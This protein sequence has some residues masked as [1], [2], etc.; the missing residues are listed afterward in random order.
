MTSV[1]LIYP[2]FKPARDTSTFRFPPLGIAYVGAALRD[3]GYQV[4]LLDCTFLSRAE[5]LEKARA[6]HPEVVGVYAMITMREDALMFARK[7]RASARLLVAGGPFPSTDPAAFL[8]DFDAVVRGEGERTI[9][10]LLSAW[11]GGLPLD[12]VP[13]V[14][15]RRKPANAASTPLTSAEGP[16]SGPERTLEPDLD[17][18]PFPARDLLPNAEYIRHGKRKYGYSITSLMSSR[19]CPFDCEFCSNV[20]FGRSNRM[21]SPE[22]VVDEVEQALSLGYERIHFADDVFTLDRGRVEAIC[23]EIMRRGLRFG[24]ECLCRVD[25]IDYDLARLMKKAGCRRVFFGIESGSDGVLRMMNKKITTDRARRAVETARRARLRTGAFFILFYPGESDAT[26]EETLRFARSLP[27]DYLS[28]TMPYPIVGTRLYQ[29]VKDRAMR[30]WRQPVGLLFDHVRV[31]DA[32]FSQA[33][34]RLAILKGSIQFEL[35]RRL[36]AAGALLS[37][38][39]DKPTALLIRMMR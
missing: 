35:K 29:R 2:Y 34:M 7:L 10:E 22:N 12:R 26:V 11:A 18:L 3:R 23:R 33:K 31:F 30:R 16:A 25:S 14:V 8:K 36:G 1:L 37:G 9:L 13:G 21:R 28:F 20:V 17:R 39:I 15:Y 19:G 5:A 24:W 27:L 6:A 38:L 32:D 4:S